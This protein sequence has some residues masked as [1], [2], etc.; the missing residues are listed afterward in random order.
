[1][2]IIMNNNKKMEIRKYLKKIMKKNLLNPRELT[3]T[4]VHDGYGYGRENTICLINIEHNGKSFDGHINVHQN[5]TTNKTAYNE[6]LKIPKG[7][8]ITLTGMP[9]I[10]DKKIDGKKL[11]D[12][13]LK[14]INKITY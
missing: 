7:T 8:K 6:L 4:A 3:I 14:N 5:E 9:D 10:Y 2:V 12:Y 11:I 13:T 1:M